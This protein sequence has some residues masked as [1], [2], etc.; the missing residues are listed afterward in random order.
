MIAEFSGGYLSCAAGVSPE[1]AALLPA[2]LPATP[3][4]RSG[5]V[6]AVARAPGAGCVVNLDAVLDYFGDAP[7]GN[8]AYLGRMA[9]YLFV[10]H[11]ATYGGLLLLA[12]RE[13]R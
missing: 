8:E 3:L 9:L 13:R 10:L 4:A 5:A 1:A 11:A 2:L 7:R 12:R 6:A